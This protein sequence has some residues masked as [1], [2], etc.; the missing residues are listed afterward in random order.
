MPSRVS[1]ASSVR[2]A[3]VRSVKLLLAHRA[4]HLVLAQLAEVAVDIERVVE[5]VLE[6]GRDPRDPRLGLAEAIGL[7]ERL[8]R[9]VDLLVREP[10]F[11]HGGVSA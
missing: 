2:T 7:G 4:G 11:G 8:Q 1:S 5:H 6:L 3:R 9:G 10:A